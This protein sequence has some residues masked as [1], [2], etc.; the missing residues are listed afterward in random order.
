MSCAL[1]HYHDV[2]IEFL[3]SHCHRSI[4]YGLIQTLCRQLYPCRVPGNNADSVSV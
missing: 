2:D 3:D 1:D 4:Q